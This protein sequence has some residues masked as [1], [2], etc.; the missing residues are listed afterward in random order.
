MAGAFNELILKWRGVDY[1]C[2][3]TMD[4]IMHIEDKVTLS[5]L[6][7][8]SVTGAQNGGIPS[9]HVAWVYYCLL[10]GAGAQ[11][12][13]EDVWQYVKTDSEA[14]NQIA[15]VIKFII[16]EVYG[17]GPEEPDDIDAGA[18]EKK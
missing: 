1:R 14:F 16:A 7:Y 12:S 4:T 17:V 10:R 18:G 6:A 13:Q 11:L 2:R 8:R 15:E 9:S 3:A 5:Q